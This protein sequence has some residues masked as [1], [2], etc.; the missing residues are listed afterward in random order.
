[1]FDT[2]GLSQYDWAW[3]PKVLIDDFPMMPVTYALF[4]G[5]NGM[6]QGKNGKEMVSEF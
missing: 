4:L 1:M 2:Y 6:L 5:W 3:V